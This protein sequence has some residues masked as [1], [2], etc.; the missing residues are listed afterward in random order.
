MKF[1]EKLSISRLV[2]HCQ[3]EFERPFNGIVC[4]RSREATEK[5]HT[6]W[7]LGFEKKRRQRL[8]MEISNTMSGS[9][10]GPAA[11]WK[12]QPVSGEVWRPTD[13][14]N[15]II[16]HSTGQPP[17]DL[18]AISATIFDIINNERLHSWRI[19]CMCPPLWSPQNPRRHWP[20]AL[21]ERWRT[22]CI[23]GSST[24]TFDTSFFFW[25][26]PKKIFIY[27]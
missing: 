13:T 26:V 15:F 19:P 16:F 8:E 18:S 3:T 20:K 12:E 23:T 27:I 17:S 9:G 25:P 1:S 7:N 2:W 10:T 21:G 11:Y 6:F 22:F 24:N 14:A 5:A 4:R